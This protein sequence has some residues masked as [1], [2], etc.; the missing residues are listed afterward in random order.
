MGAGRNL[1]GAGHAGSEGGELGLQE[2]ERITQMLQ[3]AFLP[4]SPIS[5]GLLLSHLPTLLA[6]Q[7][8]SWDFTHAH[9]SVQVRSPGNQ[10]HRLTWPAELSPCSL[11]PPPATCPGH[12]NT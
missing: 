9:H 4:F 2:L 8:S 5:Y 6:E 1:E 3:G 11:L 12:T 10:L 7:W